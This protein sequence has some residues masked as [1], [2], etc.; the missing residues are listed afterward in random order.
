MVNKRVTKSHD[1][2]MYDCPHLASSWSQSK[3]SETRRNSGIQ[4]VFPGQQAL[5]CFQLCLPIHAILD[6]LKNIFF[7]TN[8]LQNLMGLT[9]IL[10]MSDDVNTATR[11]M[12]IVVMFGDKQAA[13]SHKTL[14]I[15]QCM[16]SVKLVI[17]FHF[18]S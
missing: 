8:K 15:Y 5:S 4:N 1:F 13:K 7:E 3:I 18:I 16:N 14:S 2:L 6:I 17:P 10:S 11:T 12:S 9:N